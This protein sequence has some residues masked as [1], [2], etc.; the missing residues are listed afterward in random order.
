M[1]MPPYILLTGLWMGRSKQPCQPY[2]AHSDLCFPGVQGR[3]A[4]LYAALEEYL[5]VVADPAHFTRESQ[6]A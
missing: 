3:Q 5:K 4:A 2:T 1:A 6:R